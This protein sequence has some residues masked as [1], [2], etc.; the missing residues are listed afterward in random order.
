MEILGNRH[1][2]LLLLLLLMCARTSCCAY[3]LTGDDRR[4][5]DRIMDEFCR[6]VA[7]RLSR[8]RASVN[9]HDATVS[10]CARA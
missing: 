7:A 2:L 4:P 3:S 10:V 1:L 9:A 6:R 5:T 8:A